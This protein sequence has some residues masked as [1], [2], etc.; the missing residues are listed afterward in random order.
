MALKLIHNYTLHSEL[1]NYQDL[2][3]NTIDILPDNTI[4]S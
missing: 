3:T 4:L 2:T 1:I